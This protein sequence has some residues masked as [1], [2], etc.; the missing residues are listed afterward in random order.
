MF[1]S[2]RY[3][4]DVISL[5]ISSRDAA[6][7]RLLSPASWRR[8]VQV[9]SD[10]HQ[11]VPYRHVGAL[12][13]EF[14][15][16]RYQP[17]PALTALLNQYDLVQ[18]VA[19]TPAPALVTRAVHKPIC[20]FIATM[21]QQER[22]AVLQRQKGWRWYWLRIMTEINAQIERIA[23]QQID[24]VFAESEYTRTLLSTFLPQDRVLLGIPGIDTLIFQPDAYQT[25]G[26]ILAVGRFSDHRKN[27]RL[28]FDAYHRLRQNSTAGPRLVLAGAKPLPQDWMYAESLGITPWIDMHADVSVAEL[29]D[30]YRGASLFVLSSDEEGLG[31]VILEAMASG[32]P[33]IST[34]CGG[35]ETAVIEEETGCLTPVGDAP[36]MAD[37]MRRLLADPALRQQMGQRGRQIAEERFSIAAAG[38]VFLD[39]YDALLA[40]RD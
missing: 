12:L 24:Y 18:V 14:E 28:L 29:A 23:L 16:Q 39:Q 4:P 17:R 10:T 8:G 27:V 15:F 40:S 34:R 36:A 21:I 13:T 30:L 22:I 37:A 2:G 6:S 20:L 9:T 38:K 35:P 26:Y 7:L 3:A 1:E 25:D 31:I 32:L 19:G 33:V 11:G 5:A